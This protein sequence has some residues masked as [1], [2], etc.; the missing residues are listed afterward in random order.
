MTTPFQDMIAA[1]VATFQSL[2]ALEPQITRAANLVT[3]CL[4]GGHKVLTF[5]NGGSAADAAHLATEFVVRYVQ[6]RRPYPAVALS[7]SGSTLTAAGNDYGFDEIFARQVWALGQRGDLLI[8]FSTSGRSPNVLRALEKATDMDL[9]RVVFLG[10]D[11]GT[12]KDLATI[13]LIIPSNS[14]ARIQE[15]HGL[16]IH[17]LCEM[18]EQ[19]LAQKEQTQSPPA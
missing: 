3:Q 9:E 15:A 1:G 4:A 7:D 5:G 11:G 10:G 17:A 2:A 6:D 13:S 19:R 12:A 18:T 8:A 16:L 14:T